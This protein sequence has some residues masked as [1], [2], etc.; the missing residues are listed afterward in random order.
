[1]SDQDFILV[2]EEDKERS[3]ENNTEKNTGNNTGGEDGQPDR[4]AVT[5]SPSAGTV[6]DEIAAA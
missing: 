5:E 2:D 6:K 3:T 1:M 4:D